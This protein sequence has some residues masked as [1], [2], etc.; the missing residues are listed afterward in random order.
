MSEKVY[1]LVR[2]SSKYYGQSSDSNTHFE[3][4]LNTNAQQLSDGYYIK[5]GI[6]GNYRPND[7]DFYTEFNGGLELVK[8]KSW[9]D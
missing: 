7:L 3:V 2:K 4:T 8:R 9:V 1:A 5:G 6:G